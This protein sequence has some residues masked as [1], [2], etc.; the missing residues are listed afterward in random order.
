MRT[1]TQH[2]TEDTNKKRTKHKTM[3]PIE[4]TNDVRTKHM[5]KRPTE[6]TNDALTKQTT[7]IPTAE[8]N[9]TRTKR[10]KMTREEKPAKVEDEFRCQIRKTSISQKEHLKNQL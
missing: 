10:K 6:D 9:N 4:N 5:K 2:K 7:T 1:F 3:T 8:T